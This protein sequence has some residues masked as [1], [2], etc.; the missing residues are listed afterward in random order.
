[1]YR[2]VVIG[3]LLGLVSSKLC[4]LVSCNKWE[5]TL[6]PFLLGLITIARILETRDKK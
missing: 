3:L 5:G 4:L 1:M 6:R 2:Q